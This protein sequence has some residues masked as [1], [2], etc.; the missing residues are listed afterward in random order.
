MHIKKYIALLLAILLCG[1]VSVAVDYVEADKREFHASYFRLGGE[2]WQ[3]MEVMA[4]GGWYLCV[5]GLEVEAPISPHTLER[6]LDAYLKSG[7]VVI[8]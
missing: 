4:P 3:K 5:T 6:L 8:P 2:K 1:C 7:A